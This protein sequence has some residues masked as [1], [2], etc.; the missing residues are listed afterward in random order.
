MITFWGRRG[1]LT[2]FTLEF[3]RIIRADPQIAATVSVS[4]QNERFASFAEFAGALLAVD[5]FKSNA[6]ALLRVDRI[7]LLRRSLYQRLRRDRIQAVIE[8]MPHVWSPLVMSVVR[9]AG[10]RYCTIVH[11]AAAHPGDRT[12]L[13]KPLID[14]AALSADLVLTLSSAV[15]TRLLATGKFPPSK[16]VT[17][18]HPD[19]THSSGGE[20]E[21]RQAPMPG[22]PLRLLFLGRIM[23]YKGLDLFIETVDELRRSGLS[24]EVGVFGEGPL[25]ANAD[26][27]RRMDAEVVNRWLG[28]EELAD[29]LARYHAV[30]L[31]H[32]EASQSGVAASAFGAGTPVIATPVGGLVEQVQDGITGVLA[33]SIDAPALAGAAKRLLCDPQFY[34]S[35]CANLVQS[36]RQRSMK[37]FVSAAVSHAVCRVDR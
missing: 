13:V 4:R 25:G 18:F 21:R 6:G 28:A 24:V 19:M 36:A 32:T 3:G 29:A 26:R 17:L 22:A 20:I 14:R 37:S 1:A 31:S 33:D 2:Q 15:A 11:D 8:L 10:A 16:L 23:P 12:S 35:T 5:T 7:A 27:L 9:R 30:M 34:R